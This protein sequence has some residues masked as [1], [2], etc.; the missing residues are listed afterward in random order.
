MSTIINII[1]NYEPKIND[2]TYTII[3]LN[4]RDL[5]KKY[6]FGCICCGHTYL[7][8]KYSQLI[9]QHFNTKK[10]KRLCLEP[11]TENFNNN[12]GDSDNYADAFDKKCKENREL[13]V[14][15]Y[16]FKK[17]LEEFKKKYDDLQTINFEYQQQ[18]IHFN[19]FN[20]NQKL[21]KC[22]NLIDL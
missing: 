16:N 18:I 14:L 11:S 6:K 13:K 3:D 20:K 1:P 7:P 22:E 21:I 8:N 4:I 10:H 19:N 5:Q 9:A 12:F 2:E 17:E 15:N